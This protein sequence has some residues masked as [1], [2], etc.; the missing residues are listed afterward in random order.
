MRPDCSILDTPGY[1]PTTQLFYAPVAGFV[2]PKVPEHPSREQALAARDVLLKPIRLY[3]FTPLDRAVALS[4]EMTCACRGALGNVPAT[5]LDA[6][7]AGSGKGKFAHV[8]AGIALGRRAPAVPPGHDRKELAKRVVAHL[9]TGTAFVFLDNLEQDI[10]GADLCSVLTES[11]I[12][13]R[14]LGVSEEG[15]ID[16]KL[17][18]VIAGNGPKP[19]GDMTRR[20][21]KLCID[22]RLPDPENQEFPFDPYKLALEMRGELLAAAFTIV[23]AYVHAGKPDR[24]KQQGSF[25]E[26]SDLI[27]SALVWLGEADPAESISVAR[28]NDPEQQ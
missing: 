6:T 23:R 27:R 12:S 4:A 19:V 15:E 17:I 13:L 18:V 28:K 1:D 9:L 24:L 21:Q 11:P 26:W 20:V 5:L 7:A 3:P 14:R 8:M 16:A 22:W 2:M 25:E 10:G